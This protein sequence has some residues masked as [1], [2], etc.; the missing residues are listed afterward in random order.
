MG[1]A[2][3][4][5]RFSCLAGGGLLLA[6]LSAQAAQVLH[7]TVDK[8][9]DAY[10][11]DIDARID[12]PLAAVES[13]IT[14]FSR[15][16]RINPSIESS[17]ILARLGPR[18]TRVRT[19]ARACIAFFCRDIVQVQDVTVQAGGDVV[20]HI[21]PAMS[22]LRRGTA[23]WQMRRRDGHTR[24]HFRYDFVPSFWVPPLIG[25][26]MIKLKL[27]HE[28]LETARRIEAI[29]ARGTDETPAPA[30]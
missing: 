17:Q 18:T 13:I 14:D 27:E 11:V 15:L 16:S 22:D 25:P 19:T 1:G 7:G 5:R 20:A 29:A 8:R 3:W 4:T 12:A 2:R 6:C 21:V 10:V 30:Q 26:W 28:M 9:D 23:H 24:L